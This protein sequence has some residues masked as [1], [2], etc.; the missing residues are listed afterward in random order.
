MVG[1][2]VRSFVECGL[3]LMGTDDK[4]HKQ[5]SSLPGEICLLLAACSRAIHTFHTQLPHTI[6]AHTSGNTGRSWIFHYSVLVT[7]TLAP[8]PSSMVGISGTNVGSNS[9]ILWGIEP[10]ESEHGSKERCWD[11]Q[12]IER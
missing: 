9:K 3:I 10:R 11:R 6:H 4:Q 8:L 7:S 5:A 2:L 1:S 12:R